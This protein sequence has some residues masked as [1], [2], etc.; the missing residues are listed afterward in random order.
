MLGALFVAALY[1]V[2]LGATQIATVAVASLA[3]NASIPGVFAGGLLVQAPLF[4]AI[5]LPIDGLGVLIAVDAVVDTLRTSLNVTA[6]MAVAAI[7]ARFESQPAEAI[8]TPAR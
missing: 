8:E 3:L 1:G 5:G 2:H 6:D 4:A 7:V